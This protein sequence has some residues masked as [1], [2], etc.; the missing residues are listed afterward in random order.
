MNEARRQPKIAVVGGGP[1]GLRA[2]EVLASA[3]AA[4]TLFEQ[5]PSVGRK[6]LVA[7]RGGLNLT[8]SEPLE[9]FRKRYGHP[10]ARWSSLLARFGPDDLQ[11]WAQD[12]GIATYIGTSGRVFPQGQKAAPLLRRWV[13]LLRTRGV[14]IATRHRW[15]S[16]LAGERWMLT[17]QHASEEKTA[18][19]DAVI[20]ALGGASWPET[21]SDANWVS[22]LRGLDVTVS[23]LEPANCGWEVAWPAE[24]LERAEGLPL[25]NIVLS[26]GGERIAGECLITSYGL[27]G[28]A[29]YQLGPV[30]RAMAQPE[31]RIDLKP[32]LT[33]DQLVS[34]LPANA[35]FL[36]HARHRW[37]L[38][39]AGAAVLEATGPHSSAQAL[40]TRAKDLPIRLLRPRPIEE[41]ISSAGGVRWEEL[42]EHLMIAT[43]PGI[44][45]AG[46]MIDWEAPTGGYL[47]QGCFTTA[48]VAAEGVLRYL[49]RESFIKAPADR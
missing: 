27:E 47:L 5:K 38:G 31:V 46:E 26:A 10:A 37:K 17:F 36:A 48:T 33:V 29:L 20:L 49:N 22:I 2:A 3:G 45:V 14:T 44:F 6:F 41:A 30:L 28:G 8:H 24:L 25:K 40:A 13:S 9:R 21:G 4:V 12:L 7:G 35:R 42:D 34:R 1:A 11:R 15:T 16:L 18:E 23:P 19:A 39:D 32:D 43:R